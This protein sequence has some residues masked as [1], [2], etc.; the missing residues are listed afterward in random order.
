MYLTVIYTLPL[1]AFLL[2]CEF[3]NVVVPYIDIIPYVTHYRLLHQCH[4]PGLIFF[5]KHNTMMK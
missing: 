3:R 2:V 4:E 1:Q 5:T